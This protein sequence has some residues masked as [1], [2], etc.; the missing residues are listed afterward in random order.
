MRLKLFLLLLVIASAS[1]N[2]CGSPEDRAAAHLQKA[3]ELFD[4]E[5]YTTARIEGLNAAQ[6]EPRNVEVRF[7]LSD[8]EKMEGNFGQAVG[9]LLVAIDA[10]PTRLPFD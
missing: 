10:D 6:L 2:A 5:D 4:A 8:I 1:I 3:Q 7:L 9:H